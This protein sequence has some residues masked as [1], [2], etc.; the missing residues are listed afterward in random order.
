MFERESSESEIEEGAAARLATRMI[1]ESELPE[2][3]GD[4][5][6]TLGAMPFTSGATPFGR[7]SSVDTVPHEA[8]HVVQQR[9]AL[10]AGQY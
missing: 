9:A 1:A 6:G 8:A 4:E 5:A 7:P 2:T 10:F 3:E